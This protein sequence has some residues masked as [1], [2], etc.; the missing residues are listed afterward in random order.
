[1]RRVLITLFVITGF[2]LAAAPAVAQDTDG[3]TTSSE[4]AEPTPANTSSPP[5]DT[6]T[7][8]ERSEETTP[9]SSEGTPGTDQ[10]SGSDQNSGAGENSGTG[11]NSGT[12]EN[13]GTGGNPGTGQTP[14]TDQAPEVVEVMDAGEAVLES[15]IE[16]LAADKATICH[17]PPGNPE[18]VQF[19]EVAVSSLP[20][21][22]AHGDFVANSASDCP[23]GD[24]EDPDDDR[25]VT[26]CHFPPGNPENVQFIEISVNALQAHTEHGDFLADEESD[27]AGDPGEEDKVTICHFPPGNPENVQFI[28]ISI[29][30]L[31][32][33]I[34]QHGDFLA[35]SE[36][37][38][39]DDDDGDDGDDDEG[40]D[41]GDDDDKAAALPDTGGPS[42]WNLVL[43]VMLTVLGMAILSN[44]ESMLR[45]GLFG[46]VPAAAPSLP[47]SATID[48]A[49]D[50]PVTVVKP[51]SHLGRWT[52][53]GAAALIGVAILGRRARR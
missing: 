44:R 14:G 13:S 21:H 34:T 18:N 1:M 46:P 4:T 29:N 47:W 41:E 50:L 3:S 10:N 51:E 24:P 6:T 22:F 25:K 27:C 11:G 45:T 15:L 39:F 19:I 17:F 49:A 53:F 43:G 40:D 8:P 38:C 48:R 2:A 7:N 37:D 20:A 35:D 23:G 30:A 42:Q 31:Q 28:E 26:I 33:H 5:D 36:A 12:G 32:T 9:P 16:I 52:A